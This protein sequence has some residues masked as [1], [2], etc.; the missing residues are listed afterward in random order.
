MPV[1]DETHRHMAFVRNTI[2]QPEPPRGDPQTQLSDLVRQC[3]TST[4][5]SEKIFQ[6]VLKKI[7][8]TTRIVLTLTPPQAYAGR[9]IKDDTASEFLNFFDEEFE[10]SHGRYRIELL[11]SSVYFFTSRMFL[12]GC[13]QSI[14][15]L[16]AFIT[17]VAGEKEEKYPSIRLVVLEICNAVVAG[18]IS[19]AEPTATH[20]QVVSDAMYCLH[21]I[22]LLRY[23]LSHVF[24]LLKPNNDIQTNLIFIDHVFES[25]K[26]VVD[27]MDNNP[28]EGDCALEYKCV[29]ENQMT[30]ES[31]GKHSTLLIA[32]YREFASHRIFP[33][34]AKWYEEIFNTRPSAKDICCVCHEDRCRVDNSLDTDPTW[35]RCSRCANRYL[36]SSKCRTM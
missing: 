33:K 22:G 27:L 24:R 32:Q 30:H 25:I 36:C 9:Q 31:P 28:Y 17:W 34:Q 10:S 18:F 5:R 14:N 11:K 29:F 13:S 7:Y 4:R 8:S 15:S 6:E 20:E 16:L 3:T 26:T 1:S 35:M 21:E 23:A 2:D 19:R 12:D